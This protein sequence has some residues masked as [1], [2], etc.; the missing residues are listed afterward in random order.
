VK[1]KSEDYIF[2]FGKK[3]VLMSATILNV[4]VFC[5]SLGITRDQVAAKRMKN[6]FPVEN[7]RI[8]VHSYTKVT[9]GQSKQ[10][11]WG[12][13]LLKAANEVIDKH[14]DDRGI[15]HTHNFNIARMLVSESKHRKRMLFQHNFKNKDEMLKEHAKTEGSIIVA[16]AMHEG[17]DLRG[18]LSRFQIIA[19]MPY[20]NFYDDK[21]LARRIEIDR[22]Y[23]NWLVAL[24][25][26]QGYGRSVRNEEDFADTYVI[27]SGIWTF[28]KYNTKLLPGW[29]IEAI[30]RSYQV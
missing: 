24:K 27:D 16:P 13:K 28:L 10:K 8:Y 25:L 29:F 21:Q 26:V 6:R 19:K 20:P 15:I 23:Y 14:P 18:D 4:D 9:G 5:R 1:E 3:I 22:E 12:P 7:R 11:E 17:L 2:R 30:D